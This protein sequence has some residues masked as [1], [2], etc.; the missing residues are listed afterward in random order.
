M[1]IKKE[2]KKINRFP[3]PFCA[4]PCLLLKAVREKKI[5]SLDVMCGCLDFSHTT[6]CEKMFFFL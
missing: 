6:D 3:L 5:P 4:T 1:D 2:K